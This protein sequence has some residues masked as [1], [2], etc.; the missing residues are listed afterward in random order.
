VDGISSGICSTFG[1]PNYRATVTKWG[2][3]PSAL[4]SPYTDCIELHF[5]SLTT[6]G[7]ILTRKS[8]QS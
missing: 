1:Q 2:H 6:Q 8:H 5:W 7:C 3:H 4:G